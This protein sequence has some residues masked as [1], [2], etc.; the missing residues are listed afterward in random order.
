M[1]IQLYRLIRWA[2]RKLKPPICMF[3]K[4][5]ISGMVMGV[6]INYLHSVRYCYDCYKHRLL[7]EE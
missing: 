4:E 2:W 1:K 5:P 3:C 7:G 6:S